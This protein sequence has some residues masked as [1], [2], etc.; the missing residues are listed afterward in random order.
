[1]EV[2]L[3]ELEEITAVYESGRY[4]SAWERAKRFGP[5]LGWSPVR[6]RVLAG[7]LAM[8]LGAERLGLFLH[9]SAR[10]QDR[11]DPEV[12]YFSARAVYARRGPL[13]AW[14][15]LERWA[16]SDDAP[17]RVRADWLSLRGSVAA[18]FRDF[19]LA[20]RCHAQ[21]D[22]IDPENPWTCVERAG[23]LSLQDRHEEAL[24]VAR[25]ALERQ[26]WFRPAV[27]SVAGLLWM[28]GRQQEAL[29]LLCTAD[30]RLE[31]ATLADQ[32]ASL[33]FTV[34]RFDDAARSLERYAAL[35]PL[36]DDAGARRLAAR[37]SDVF[38][39][40]GEVAR[41]IEEARRVQSPFYDE[42]ARRLG[43]ARDE[44]PR[45]MLNV[46]FV[47]Q[48]HLTCSPAS[49]ASLTAFWGRPVDHRGLARAITYDGTPGYKERRWAEENGWATREFR[50]TWDAAVE[51]LERGVPFT[52]ATVGAESAHEQV[53]MGY[54]A[55]R[56]VFLIRDPGG[57]FPKEVL[58]EPLL[59]D[60]EVV[61]P[62]GF[63]ALP[64]ERASLL[65]GLTLPDES[66]YDLL[67]ELDVALLR[68]AREIAAAALQRLADEAKEHVV[69]IRAARAL[70]AYDADD[71]AAD[72]AAAV[73]LRRFPETAHALQARLHSLRRAGRREEYLDLLRAQCEGPTSNP[74]FWCEY[75]EALA[76]DARDWGQ[77]LRLL[78]R[79]VHLFP[80]N[81]GLLRALA[82][83]LWRRR[84][85]EEAL[86]LYRLAACLDELNE[87]LALTYF[88]AA[89]HLRRTDEAIAFLR[90]RASRLGERSS[91]S[92]QSLFWA[93]QQLDRGDDAFAVLEQALERH[94]ADG[95]LLLQAADAYARYG[96]ADRAEALMQ[97]ARS[98]SR[99][100][101]LLRSEAT[102]AAYRGD[103]VEALRRWRELVQAEPLAMD[104]HREVARLTASTEGPA[105]AL[106][107]TEAAAAAMPHHHGLQQ[108]WYE[109]AQDAGV[110]A[111]ARPL[112][113]LIALNPGDAWARRERALELS[114]RQRHA[115]AWAEIEE[116]GRLDSLN[117]SWHGVRGTLLARSGR[118]DE[119]RAAFREALHRAPDYVFALNELME[120]ALEPGEGRRQLEYVHE[121]L[122]AGMTLGDSL[123]AYREHCNVH[124]GPDKTL[125]ALRDL[126][127]ARREL[128]QT[129]SVL[130][131]QLVAVNR[132][133]EA[134]AHAQA[135]VEEF[136][137]LPGLWLDLC[138]VHGLRGAA[139]SERAAAEQAVAVGPLHGP[140]LRRLA[141]LCDQHAE[142]GRARSLLEQAVARAPLDAF[143]HGA[144]GELLFRLGEKESAI[145]C[146]E[147][148]LA[149]E[150]GYEWAWGAL[151]EWCE[152]LKRRDRAIALARELT[153]R[154]GGEARSWMVLARVLRRPEDLE[155]R[156]RALD[157][158][159]ALQPRLVEAYDVKA[160]LLADARRF[161]AALAACRPEAFGAT[162]PRELRGRAAWV[163]EARGDRAA[164]IRAMRELLAE[165]PTYHWGLSRLADWLAQEQ[166]F[167]AYLQAA[168]R[169][170][171][172]APHHA[173][174]LGYRGDARVRNG[175]RAGGKADLRRALE[176]DDSY[177]FARRELV[178]L[179][180]EDKEHDLAQQALEASSSVPGDDSRRTDLVLLHAAHGHQANALD[181]LTS[182]LADP[183]LDPGWLEPAFA[184][185]AKAGWQEA[186]D[187]AVGE[188][189]RAPG[190]HPAV[191]RIW[192]A[193]FASRDNFAAC[194]ERLSELQRQ[195]AQLVP[196][197][198]SFLEATA[199]ARAAKAFERALGAHRASIESDTGLWGSVGYVYVA[200][201]D[202][203]AARRW[204][205]SWP[206]RDGVRPWMLYNLVLA[207]VA[208][209]AWEQA[210][211]VN[212]AAL[213]LPPDHTTNDHAAWL[214]AEEALA[215]DPAAAE[216]L[217]LKLEGATLDER[218]EFLRTLALGV[219]GLRRGRGFAWFRGEVTRAARAFPA[220]AGG[221][222]L[223]RAYLRSVWRAARGQRRLGPALWA[224]YR[225][226]RAAR[227]APLAALASVLKERPLV[228]LTPAPT[229]P[230]ASPRRRRQSDGCP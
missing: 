209:R 65:A 119:A 230:D 144:L 197:L 116:A 6:A 71:A 126:F 156:L 109:W 35:S 2:P 115:E 112:D 201:D 180:L 26:A 120:I 25:E 168:S 161:D 173:V 142:T 206:R 106:A 135:A 218:F 52:L 74:A 122:K 48:D 72:A 110:E 128:W 136:P 61:G 99:P 214:L 157:R 167:P 8:N 93:L 46:P 200:L 220:F 131:Q 203:A 189:I 105:A 154:R 117:P 229:A 101:S 114:A 100:A 22:A 132:L 28:L 193:R 170:V 32:R 187:R 185:L 53:V 40:Q 228:V 202:H 140:A 133:D 56:G 165:E 192:I 66:L 36:L 89:R 69:T 169:M 76:L 14:R 188:A 98:C 207:L 108:L 216:E 147:R 33:E 190:C 177:V 42:I 221:T 134:A 174:S 225:C 30:E 85:F 17:G 148:A 97:A 79:G 179:H 184:E 227:G 137:L 45:R 90:Q 68:H 211:A 50:V 204:L 10:R 175:D 198:T 37:R 20:D 18:A 139:E 113:H 59:Q 164:A 118:L 27:Q 43:E 70:A 152:S 217:A 62:R 87:D 222:D 41:A 12:A 24:A 91:R 127:D 19:D 86:T 224:L 83:A 82:D 226:V 11:R 16:P 73:L 212:R 196:A 160:E 151:F 215:P 183:H 84:D 199:R 88:T 67:Y 219:L 63:V 208:D 92:V 194:L 146:L 182:W 1:M 121:Q 81:A 130:T 162:Q 124:F 5:L 213:A 163:L 138:Q 49:F 171:E 23:V 123:A 39:E 51:L 75:A 223:R 15:L 172:L 80:T 95:E 21:A 104:A 60:Q 176:L 149:L 57:P 145:A 34:G 191:G 155:E 94:P 31:S 129:W 4:L 96:R 158:A 64:R 205:A 210:L 77:A 166:A 78:R 153:E 111:A 54:D 143:N 103:T 44:L 3:R 55:R 29:E 159:V 107:Y 186:V 102:L 58:A 38:Y 195:P 181:V 9:L 13:V 47:Q 125:R 178:R 7:R 150:P 141:G